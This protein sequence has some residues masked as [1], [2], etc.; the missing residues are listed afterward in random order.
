MDVFD[1]VRAARGEHGV[2]G[3]ALGVLEEGAERHEGY[4]VTSVENPLEVTPDTRFQVGS[5]TKTFTGTAI[6]ELAARGELDL[7][8]PVR[9]YLPDLALADADA[10]ERVTLR[11]LLSH[12]GGWFGDYFDDTGWGDDAAAVYVE[13]MRDLPQQTP[14]GE[15]WAYNNAGFVLAGR[16]V[17]V[18]T[19]KRFEDVVQELVLDPLELEATT[20]WPWEVMTERFAVGHLGFGEELQVARPW[21]VGRYA[22]APG[23]IVSTTPDLLRYARLHLDPPPALA[24]MREPQAS[25][26]EEGEWVGLTWYGADRFGTLRHS[27]GT[28]GQLSLLVLVPARS[29]AFALLTN[30]SPGGLQVINAALEAAGLAAGE[31]QPVGDVETGDY[32]GVFET[33]VSRVTLAPL[34]GGRMR[35]QS[36][37]LGGFPAKD[38]P[39]GPQPP[40]AEAFFYTP[41]R[42]YVAEGPLKGMRGHFIRGD[43]GAVRWLRVG[44]RLYRR[45]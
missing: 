44:G 16:V 34:D 30:H 40:P 15:L 33:T 36:E 8:R 38:S 24:P 43:G 4:G 41:E 39:P 5:I 10:T 42:W 14:V 22:H 19:G 28:N 13:R 3:V 37:S 32:V 20:F 31:P 17:E 1:A 27:G 21:P 9:E 7:D 29:F 25:T 6:C 35:V 45:V 12:T 18:V 2:P 23:G 26:A 11:H